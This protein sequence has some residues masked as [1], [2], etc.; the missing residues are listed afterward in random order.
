MSGMSGIEVLSKIKE[1]DG[2]TEI[3]ILSALG[4]S[5]TVNAALDMGANYYMEKPIEF[6]RLLN[7]LNMLQ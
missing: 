6:E 5:T 4:D 3:I 7:I 1:I 2:N